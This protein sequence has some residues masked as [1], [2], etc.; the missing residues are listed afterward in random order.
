MIEQNLKTLPTIE[1]LERIKRDYP[2]VDPDSV[3]GVLRL[4]SVSKRL[5]RAYSD[6]FLKFGLTEA[7]FTVLMLL[8]RASQHTLLPSEIAAQSGITRSSATTLL[9]GLLSRGLIYRK[10]S[11]TD[12][13]KMVIS[14]T[15]KGEEVLS[16]ILPIHYSQTSSVLSEISPSEK[17]D[18]FK[19]LK[20]VESGIS[21][22]E[23]ETQKLNFKKGR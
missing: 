14:L 4:M 9:D 6:F 7:K 20:K 16:E 21:K 5:T 23:K 19:I 2:E 12:R 15:P 13:R 10:A 8:F 18:L 22:Y 3:I 17:N 1:D 11:K